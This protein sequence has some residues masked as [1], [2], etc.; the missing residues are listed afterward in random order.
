MKD[1]IIISLLIGAVAAC[2][3]IGEDFRGSNEGLIEQTCPRTLPEDEL[4]ECI[5]GVRQ[6][7]ADQRLEDAAQI[8]VDE[9]GDFFDP[10]ECIEDQTGTE[11][12]SPYCNN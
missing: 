2:G 6:A 12:Q 7:E 1:A 8:G 11:P 10:F 5:E 4:A 9:D 3:T